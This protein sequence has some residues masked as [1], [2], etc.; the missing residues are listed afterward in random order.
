[1]CANIEELP[2]I[3]W[4]QLERLTAEYLSRKGYN[5]ELGP[6][7]NDDGV[8]MR[9]WPVEPSSEEAPLVIVQC[10]RQYRKVE[11]VVV[12][13]L[14][15]DVQ[16]NEANRGLV[17]TTSTLTPGAIRT[18]NARGYGVDVADRATIANWLIT[19]QSPG[20]GVLAV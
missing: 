8:D 2:E 6:G 7:S 19:M 10:K 16:A 20:A 17:V 15:A 1:L 4:R 12:K 11:K 13:S 5:V 3:H 18:I 9:M 14:W